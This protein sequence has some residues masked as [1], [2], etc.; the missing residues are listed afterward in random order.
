MSLSTW[1]LIALIV[2]LFF[3]AMAL[4]TKNFIYNAC[5]TA[6]CAILLLATPN[7]LP[8]LPVILCLLISIAGDYFMGHQKASELFYLF[9]IATFFLAHACLIWYSAN[10]LDYSPWQL[11]IGIALAVAYGIYLAFRVLPNVAEIQLR[12]AIVAY[13]CASIVA[14]MMGIAMNLPLLQRILYAVG[15]ASIVA[16]DTLICETDFAGNH[17][18]APAIMP[19]YFACHLLITASI[20]VAS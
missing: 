4:Y 7:P 10:K 13:A 18:P 3:A 12:I 2:P 20:L 16:S 19:T 5:A 9:G 8:I 15:V 14:L 6:T 17:A 11:W 1:L